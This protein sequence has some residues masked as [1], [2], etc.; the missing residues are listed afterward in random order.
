MSTEQLTQ[1]RKLSSDDSKI[2]TT[3]YTSYGSDYQGNESTY[4]LPFIPQM[5]N[6][7]NGTIA[8]NATHYDTTL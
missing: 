2:D 8:L 3:W 5:F 4:Y 7:D 1:R 6:L